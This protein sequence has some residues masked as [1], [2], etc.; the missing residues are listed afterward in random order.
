MKHKGVRKVNYDEISLVG[1][2]V[3]NLDSNEFWADMLR[4]RR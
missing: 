2:H 1:D 4:G 3:H